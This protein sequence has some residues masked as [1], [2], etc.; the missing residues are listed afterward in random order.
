M[1]HGREYLLRLYFRIMKMI[2]L[3][4]QVGEVRYRLRQRELFSNPL[5]AEE[6]LKVCRQDYSTVAGQFAV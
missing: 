6:D 2:F 5:P 4:V 1:K 3:C